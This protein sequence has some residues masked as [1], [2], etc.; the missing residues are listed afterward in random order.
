MKKI[1][2]YTSAQTA[3]IRL[4]ANENNFGLQQKIREAIVSAVSEIDFNRYPDSDETELL[5]AYSAVSGVP[6]SQLLAGN[7][8]D[9]MLGYMIGT[10][11]GKG[12]KL[13][14]LDPDFSMYDYYA[15]SYEAGVEKFKINEDG[16]FDADEFIKAA[17]DSGAAMVLFSNPNNPTGNCLSIH[18]IEK[19]TAACADIPV[20]I[21][22]AYMDFSDEQ[23]A[24][25]LIDKYPNLYV[26][27]TLSKAFGMA[28][29]RIGFLI[30]NETNMARLKK[31]F[32]PY[33][34]NS[35]SMKAACVILQY[36]DEY[37][38]ETELI[39]RERER[40]YKALDKNSAV[41]V[42]DS[43][44]NFIYGKSDKKDDLLALLKENNIVIRDYAGS[45][46]F[47]ISIGT[48]QENDIILSVFEQFEEDAK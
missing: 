41:T 8:S 13:I 5:E 37:K 18:S 44:A 14:T 31:G 23:S 15:S 38:R 6:S 33:A 11:L 19:I 35:M 43:S 48:P 16:T 3:G 29:I 39:K 45:P 20:I 4:N 26:T 30:S 9:Q 24:I 34:L 46:Y 10:F 2:S 42:H 40:V 1:R 21:D 27:R 36:A 47:R 25:T 32:V 28:G 7:G 17:K 22:E 12:K